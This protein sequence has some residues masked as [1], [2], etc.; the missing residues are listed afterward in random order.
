L[1]LKLAGIGRGVLPDEVLEETE[2]ISEEV[3]V[4]MF[5]VVGDVLCDESIDIMLARSS[6]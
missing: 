4:T 5:W 1:L 6:N 3:G 2:A